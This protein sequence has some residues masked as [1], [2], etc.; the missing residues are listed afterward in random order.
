[1]K[2][3]FYISS[4]KKRYRL[5]SGKSYSIGRHSDND[6][7]FTNATVSRIHAKI[8]WDNDTFLIEDLN[9][10]N[11]TFLNGTKITSARLA[12]K[13]IIRIG[14]VELEFTM[15]RPGTDVMEETISPADSIILENR[16][17]QIMND[18]EDP[19]IKERFSEIKRL[20][21]VKKK[22][23]SDLAYSD[24]L[25]GLYNRRS[26]DKKLADEWKRRK[27]YKRPLSLIMIDIDHFKKVNDT[28]G[29]QKGDAVLKTVAGIVIDNMRLSDYPCRYGGE[30]MAVI[31]SETSKKDAAVA[32]EKLR[33]L[34]EKSVKEIEG[35]RVT[36]SLGVST[37]L[38]KMNEPGDLIKAADEC[39]YKAKQSGRNKVVVC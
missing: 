14:K 22:N 23:L 39:L 31:L 16:I 18:V 20:F 13:D 25:T 33:K 26:F 7:F 9:S 34:V 27:R 29:H 4:G 38:E 37:Y 6:I 2:F 30:E 35:I 10:T 12:S 21:N 28:Y 32:A 15:T 11:G 19:L 36:I 5:H 17:Q 8:V 1:M 3:N 24:N